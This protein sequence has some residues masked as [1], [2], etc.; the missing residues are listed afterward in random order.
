MRIILRGTNWIGDAVMAVPAMRWVRTAFPDAAISLLTRSWAKGI[1][2][3]ADFVDDLIVVESSGS[4]LTGTLRESRIFR[5]GNFDL[6]ILFPNSFSSALAAWLAGIPCRIGF[7]TQHRGFLLSDRVSVPD[8][9]NTRHESHYYLELAYSAETRFTGHRSDA[10]PELFGSLPVAE[11]R[12]SAARRSLADRGV[13]LTRAVIAI[14]AGSTNSEAKR[15][16]AASYAEVCRRL[17]AEHAANIVL[18]GSMQ[19]KNVSA[20]IA[21][22]MRTGVTDLTGETC[23]DEA[24]AILSVADLFISN[25]MGLA[26]VSAAVGT[27]TIVIFG[28]TNDVT[29]GPVGRRVELIREPVECSPCM[30]RNCPIDHRC[31]TRISPERVIESAAKMLETRD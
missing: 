2:C 8:W 18:L 15:W 22:T 1:F 11:E 23:L 13:D 16:P 12:R 6:A 29:T 21:Q 25:D 26:H 9:K 5:D 17:H 19:E 20:A 27:P 24:V 3:D 4:G 30:L 31:M 10:E 14:G 28:P 7:D